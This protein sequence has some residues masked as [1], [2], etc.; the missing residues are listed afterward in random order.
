MKTEF[1]CVGDLHL[2]KLNNYFEK[3]DK[4]VFEQLDKVLA[5]ARK[6]K[7][8]R[9]VQLGDI[10]DNSKPGQEAIKD[11][12]EYLHKNNDLEFYFI[13]GN[14]DYFSSKA[15]ATLLCSFLSES[16]LLNN[17]HIYNKPNHKQIDGIDFFFSP[18]PNYEKFEFLKD[19]PCLCFGHFE[20]GG[21][22]NDNGMPVKS[23]V[24]KA[25]L[26]PTDFWTIGHLHRKQEMGRIYYPG[27]ALQ[28]SF[29]EPLPKGFSVIRASLS[30][31]GELDVDYEFVKL[32][33]PYTF[34]NI[35]I[36]NQEEF[37]QIRVNDPNHLYKIH[38]NNSDIVVPNQFLNGSITNI[39][40]IVNNSNSKGTEV[41]STRTLS[42]DFND[43]NKENFFEPLSGLEEYLEKQGFSEEERVVALNQVF[44]LKQQYVQKR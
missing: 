26:D 2:E 21:A 31:Q 9:I 11:F 23:G 4:F 1:I 19:K 44:E 43:N 40:K 28:L 10:F 3:G 37:N 25:K 7:I 32:E 6:E 29:G 27:T 13:S 38:I 41:Q 33:T 5:F 14:H 24:P 22:L 16:K 20:I 35:Y 8:S 30:K 17:V 15:D 42:E 36:E 39:Y 12:I 18:F 34:E